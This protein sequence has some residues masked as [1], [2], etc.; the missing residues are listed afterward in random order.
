MKKIFISYAAEDY[1]YAHKLLANLPNI[2]VEGWMDN[3]D[4]A[5]GTALPEL[6]RSA[7]K[8]TNAVVVLLS[9]K[10]LHSRW[11]NFEIGAGLALGRPIILIL[12]EGAGL[13]DELP[14]IF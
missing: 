10:S 9:P 6:V 5:A 2:G 1:Q 13:E 4:I 11:V 7:I 3:A 8:G 12:V 14:E